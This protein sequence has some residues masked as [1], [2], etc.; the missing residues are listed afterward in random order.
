[1]VFWVPEVRPILSPDL[2]DAHTQMLS[3]GVARSEVTQ[4]VRGS[5]GG[6]A[7]ACLTS[8]ALGQPLLL[9]QPELGGGHRICTSFLRVTHVRGW[10]AVQEEAGLTAWAGLAASCSRLHRTFQPPE[11]M[12]PGSSSGP[13]ALYP[14]P[15]PG[16]KELPAGPGAE[17]CIWACAGPG[18]MDS[19]WCGWEG[20]LHLASSMP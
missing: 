20:I 11:E 17:A 7:Q 2:L 12:E 19:L 14:S 5:S 10:L 8:E 3:D 1:M 13:G 9:A 6:A 4:Q 15:T 16:L 18:R